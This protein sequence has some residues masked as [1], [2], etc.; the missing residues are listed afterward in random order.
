M[1]FDK[2]VMKYF[3]ILSRNDEHDWQA[4]N[5]GVCCFLL[6]CAFLGYTDYI[7]LI[8]VYFCHD[9]CDQS[10]AAVV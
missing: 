10:S 5:H 7:W 4:V 1:Y 8:V 3:F 2:T 9:P 6:V